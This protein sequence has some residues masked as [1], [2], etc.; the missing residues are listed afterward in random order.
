[1]YKTI[2]FDIDGTL[3]DTEE[4]M[5]RSLQLALQEVTQ[6]HYDRED[7]SFILG[8]PGDTA[9]KKLQL[10]DEV[11]EKE[12]RARWSEKIKHHAH[13]MRVFPGIE[14][15]LEKLQEKGL[16]LGVV[17]SKTQHEYQHDFKPFG[18]TRFFTHYV[19]SDDTRKHKPDAEPLI[20]FLN[21]SE[22]KAE[23]ALYIGDTIY[24]EQCAHT[25]GIDFA[26]AGWGAVNPENHHPEFS[27]NQ[28]AEMKRWAESSK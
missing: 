24:D 6:Q 18:L 7:L 22:S 10:P 16:T 4:T 14:E 21:K 19:C 27:F 13:F 1:M 23:E 28:P 8:I 5:I 25:A 12:V 15:L 3:I 2:I 17:T 9:V 20:H 26:L 11:T